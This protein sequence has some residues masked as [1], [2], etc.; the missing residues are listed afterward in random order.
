[1]NNELTTTTNRLL[2]ESAKVVADAKA[3][4]EL[5]DIQNSVMAVKIAKV[6]AK[7]PTL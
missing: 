7:Y 6:L 2:A 4:R 1:M 3:T 5:M